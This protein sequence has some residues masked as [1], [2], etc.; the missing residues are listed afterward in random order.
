MKKRVVIITCF[1]NYSYEVRMK[2]VEDVFREKGYDVIILSANFD[3][4]KKQ[5]YLCRRN[6]LHLIEVPQYK[7]NISLGRIYSHFIFG[8]KVYKELKRINPEILYASAPPNFIFK[9]S[10]LY[11]RY[12]PST[13]LIYDISDMW[14]ET[15]P[16]SRKMKK[17]LTIPLGAWRHIRDSAIDK[18]DAYI[19]E[20]KL[21]WDYL[22][23]N[24]SNKPYSIIYLCRKKYDF[25]V[26]KLNDVKKLNF[27][28][29]GSVNNIIDINLIVEFLFEVNKYKPV[30][31]ILIGAG[32]KL[33]CLCDLCKER[34]IK[35]T[36][37][38]VVYDD[39]KKQQILQ[40]CSFGLNIMKDEVFVGATM[41]SLEYF[42]W[43][44][45]LI[46]N[47]PADTSELVEQYECGYNISW[48]SYRK[49]A[50]VISMLSLDEINNMK[51]NSHI[52]FET[53]FSEEIMKNKYYDFFE[54]IGI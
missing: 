8:K 25:K 20:C 38:G 54:K 21:F 40:S 47:I 53:Y 30:E 35:Y 22:K 10:A 7:K 31:L 11:K 17:I 26:E 44:L 12:N 29:I 24:I 4:R 3:H 46:N 34:N 37:H 36:N 45:G 33:E 9:Y 13:N 6:G 16:V 50:K 49:V 51:T 27:S 2:Y 32:E 41:K 42:H 48:N 52:I 43:G 19:Y 5:E 28:Y 15:L 23:K 1:D 14:P 39:C 18:A